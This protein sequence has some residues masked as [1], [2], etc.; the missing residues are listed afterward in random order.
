MAY[1][2][3]LEE[4][5]RYISLLPDLAGSGLGSWIHAAILGRV[6]GPNA[7]SAGKR[8]DVRAPAACTAGVV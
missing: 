4:M 3:M 2:A 8:I 5:L 1:S 6:V 7:S